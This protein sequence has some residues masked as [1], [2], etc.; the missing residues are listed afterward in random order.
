MN[1]WIYAVL[2][3]AVLAQLALIFHHRPVI[4]VATVSLVGIASYWLP[5]SFRISIGSTELYPADCVALAVL[6]ATAFGLVTRRC[7]TSHGRVWCV[8][9]LLLAVAVA[10][11]LLVFGAEETGNAV[12]GYVQFF[13][14]TLFFS[15]VPWKSDIMRALYWCWGIAAGVTLGV[16]LTFW[17][18]NGFGD[19]AL[20]ERALTSGPALVLAQATVMAVASD[21]S[22]VLSRFLA[23]VGL[24]SLLLI[25][26]RTVWLVVAVSLGAI[27]ALRFGS[28]AGV[29]RARLVIAAGVAA[30]AL[31]VIAGPTGLSRSL[32][33]AVNEPMGQEST[34]AWRLDGWQLLVTRRADV[35]VFDLLAGDPAGT[36]FERRMGNTVTEVSPHN[37]YVAVLNSFGVIGLAVFVLGYLGIIKRLTRLH[38]R[39]GAE[40]N[41]AAVLL[42]LVLGQLTY[43]LGYGTSI[44]QGVFTGLAGALAWARLRRAT[45]Q[46]H[47]E[48]AFSH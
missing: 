6:A 32:D 44:E 47:R 26:Q 37:Y 2:A 22:A 18:G 43:F 28:D 7:S 20:E 42:V 36:G 10:R 12:R 48:P 9:L 8:L 5:E 45:P 15:A 30:L 25:Q 29:R 34:L 11:G 19:F 24:F 17:L 39:A 40:A 33:R 46:E 38:R 3:A 21:R 27:A 23:P 41:D 4:A 1:P 13:A 35:P 14:A 16:A 31:L